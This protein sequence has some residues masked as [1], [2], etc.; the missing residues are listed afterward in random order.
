MASGSSGESVQYTESLSISDKRRYLEK[1]KEIGDPYGYPVSALSQDDLPPV[2]ILLSI[3][4]KDTGSTKG[5]PVR[6]APRLVT[7]IHTQ[8]KIQHRYKTTLTNYN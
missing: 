2:I 4:S 3:L 8:M 5:K 1:T 6:G 7:Y